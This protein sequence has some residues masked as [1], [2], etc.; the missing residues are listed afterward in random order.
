MAS[1]HLEGGK[2]TPFHRTMPAAS[3]ALPSPPLTTREVS[4]HGGRYGAGRPLEPGLKYA[5]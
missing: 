2:A 3:V 1:R 4:R 5:G